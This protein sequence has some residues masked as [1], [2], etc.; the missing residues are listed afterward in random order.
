MKVIYPKSTKS[1]SKPANR[2]S[3][4]C[5]TVGE[6]SLESMWRGIHAENAP[7]EVP[8]GAVT[9]KRYAELNNITRAAADYELRTMHREKRLNSGVFRVAVGT[10]R[11]NEVRHYWP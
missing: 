9:V 10:G 5:E 8:K 4:N 7:Q 11:I 2:P 1:I 6:A 3:S